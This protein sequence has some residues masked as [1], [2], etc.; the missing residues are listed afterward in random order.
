M[1]NEIITGTI[2]YLCCQCS[3]QKNND[4]SKVTW[5]C[6]E[7]D[8]KVCRHCTLTFVNNHGMTQYYDLTYCSKSC[9][10]KHDE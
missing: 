2:D 1:T 4:G 6:C 7:C 5:V 8:Q 10:D 3:R 9:K